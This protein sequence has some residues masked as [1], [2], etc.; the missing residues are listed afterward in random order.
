MKT[1]GKLFGLLVLV[2]TMFAFTTNAETIVNDSNSELG[3]YYLKKAAHAMEVNDQEV[4]TYVI[5][6][7][8][9]SKPVYIGVYSVPNCK[10]FLV[11]TDDFEVAYACRDGIFGI[12]YM[13]ES[14]ATLPAEKSKASID[15]VNYLRQR[16]ITQKK[17]T[18]K[19]QLNL[20][21][22]YLPDIMQ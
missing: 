20:I 18:E 6:Y 15:R 9:L 21:A 16:V 17:C 11:R 10:I 13:P 7:D 3:K 5:H 4:P 14:L 8:N 2:F 1:T 19:T 12:N 22:Q